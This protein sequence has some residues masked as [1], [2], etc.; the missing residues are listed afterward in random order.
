MR[1]YWHIFW[2]FNKFYGFH[3]LGYEF[4]YILFFSCYV[5]FLVFLAF[6]CFSKLIYG[7]IWGFS[8]HIYEKRWSSAPLD[9]YYAFWLYVTIKKFKILNFLLYYFAKTQ[10]KKANNCFSELLHCELFHARNYMNFMC[11]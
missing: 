4:S 7:W 2:G 5:F 3:F 11:F 10:N 9:L 8:I 1:I 6:C